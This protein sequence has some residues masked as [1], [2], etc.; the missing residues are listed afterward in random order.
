MKRHKLNRLICLFGTVI[1]VPTLIRGEALDVQA[2]LKNY[3][4][5]LGWQNVFPDSQWSLGVVSLRL[6]G[7]TENQFLVSPPIGRNEMIWDFQIVKPKGSSNECSVDISQTFSCHPLELF[8]VSGSNGCHN[9]FALNAEFHDTKGTDVVGDLLLEDVNDKLTA[10]SMNLEE[11]YCS[12]KNAITL[13]RVP[14]RFYEGYEMSPVSNRNGLI[15]M[16]PREPQT[17]EPEQESVCAVLGKSCST[18]SCV[19]VITGMVSVVFVDID[20]NK[21]V[22]FYATELSRHKSGKFVWHL[23]RNEDGKFVRTD[24][25]VIAGTNDFCR[26]ITY[27]RDPQLVIL[28]GPGGSPKDIRRIITDRYF[29]RIERLPCQTCPAS[30]ADAKHSDIDPRGAK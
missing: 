14:I 13:S 5:A 18:E 1:L 10:R 21:D 16:E 15:G 11:C 7:T 12:E 4:N 29:H 6:S 30:G 2:V 9:V 22:D 25:T 23:Y 20:N 3:T 8:E 26:V 24:R 27:T 17:V 28:G 19:G